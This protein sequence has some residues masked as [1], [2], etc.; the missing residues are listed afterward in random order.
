MQAQRCL[1][2]F[3]HPLPMIGHGDLKNNMREHNARAP[4]LITPTRDCFCINP[5]ISEELEIEKL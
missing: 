1:L 5:T 2:I 4:H 3:S